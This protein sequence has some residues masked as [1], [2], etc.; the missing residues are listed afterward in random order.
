MNPGKRPSREI[1]VG[2]KP[3]HEMTP[4]MTP[5]ARYLQPKSRHVEKNSELVLFVK[6][7]TFL[8]F[9]TQKLLPLK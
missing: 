8:C 1:K 5:T 9:L 3:H 7:R 6:R 4:Q 2:K